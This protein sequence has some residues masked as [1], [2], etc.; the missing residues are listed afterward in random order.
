MREDLILEQIQTYG[1]RKHKNKNRDEE[2][3]SKNNFELIKK[4]DK[5][6][7]R[8]IKKTLSR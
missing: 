4:R 3:E 1:E 2:K 5:D 6:R 7:K 8:V